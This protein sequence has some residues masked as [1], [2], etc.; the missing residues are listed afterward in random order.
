MAAPISKVLP[1]VSARETQAPGAFPFGVSIATLR[2]RVPWRRTLR[3]V[4]K[5]SVLKNPGTKLV[6][7]L[8]VLGRHRAGRVV[9]R[10]GVPRTPRAVGRVSPAIAAGRPGR[11]VQ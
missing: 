7:P 4:A 1:G 11:R 10:S 8:L 6:G 9:A 2:S 5:R 3:S